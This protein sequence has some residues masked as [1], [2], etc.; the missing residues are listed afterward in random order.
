MRLSII[1]PA[2]NEEA[3][4]SKVLEKVFS[5]PSSIEREVIV[6]DDGS[7]DG[8]LQILGSLKPKYNFKLISHEKN[9]G[10]GAAIKSGIREAL[11]THMIIQDADLEYD[12]REI[13]KLLEKMDESVWAVYGS[14][15][16]RIVP[17]R[18]AH[19]IM[20]AKL[21][22]LTIN[23]LYGAH[24]KD[25]YTGY[26]L[27]NLE[28]MNKETFLNLRSSGFEFEAEITCKILKNKGRIIEVPIEYTPRGKSHG[29]KINF[30]DAIRGF[31]TTISSLW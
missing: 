9:L 28:K 29:K 14:R 25:A 3:F 21:L 4:I 30:K 20:G 6:V 26:K 12:P 8:T 2:Y 24:L 11:G 1:I 17:E 13:P 18:G 22:T 10:K 15:P 5:I 27:F 16:S 19:Y 31:I 7:R 23:L